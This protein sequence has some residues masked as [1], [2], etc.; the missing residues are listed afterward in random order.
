[1]ACKRSGVRI[2]LAPPLA[3]LWDVLAGQG[4][5]SRFALCLSPGHDLVVLPVTVRYSCWSAGRAECLRVRQTVT[6]GLSGFSFYF[7]CSQTCRRKHLTWGFDLR[8]L[9]GEPCCEPS[10]LGRACRAT[11]RAAL[12]LSL[13]WTSDHAPYRVQVPARTKGH[14]VEQVVQIFEK[15]AEA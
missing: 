10:R 4:L 2:P 6:P 7:S 11:G 9:M 14:S 8:V 5:A 13:V 1:M 12:R 15:Q 3:P